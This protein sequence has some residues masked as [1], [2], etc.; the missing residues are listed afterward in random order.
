MLL[1]DIIRRY[2]ENRRNAQPKY[3]PWSNAFFLNVRLGGMYSYQLALM[4]CRKLYSFH[5]STKSISR[6]WFRA[7]SIIILN[8]NKPDAR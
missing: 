8:K 3:T 4:V 2:C 6:S 7:S 1:R 5:Q